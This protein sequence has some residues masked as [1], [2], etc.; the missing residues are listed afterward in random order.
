MFVNC[1]D[2]LEP[3]PLIWI[4]QMESY[5]VKTA[6]CI[7]HASCVNT[8]QRMFTRSWWA[9]TPGSCVIQTCVLCHIYTKRV[10][11]LHKAHVTIV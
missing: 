4:L 7:L 5:T 6:V 9:H 1:L 2:I 8:T 3:H 10:L 11:Y